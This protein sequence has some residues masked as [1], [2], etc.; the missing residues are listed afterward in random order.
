M[1]SKSL[2]SKSL[3][4]LSSISTRHRVNKSS[5]LS[6]TPPFPRVTPRLRLAAI[7]VPACLLSAC[8]PLYIFSKLAGLGVGFGFFG[9]PIIRRGLAILN[10]DFPHWQ[11]LFELQKQVYR[12]VDQFIRYVT[13]SFIVRF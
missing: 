9:D 12:I 6:P 10:R 3:A 4:L 1:R 7:L 5:A 8:T 11:R 2:R 13:N